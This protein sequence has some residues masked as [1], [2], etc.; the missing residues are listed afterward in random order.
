M[1]LQETELQSQQIRSIYKE[2]REAY[3]EHGKTDTYA[4]LPQIKQVCDAILSGAQIN[5]HLFWRYSI[6]WKKE[7]KERP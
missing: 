5:R 1:T 2:V 6:I 4:T 7:M 3:A